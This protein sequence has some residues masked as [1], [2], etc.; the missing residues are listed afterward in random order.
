MS[1]APEI[2]ELR[3][4]QLKSDVSS[5][6]T[7]R[8]RTF[9]LFAFVMLLLEFLLN[10]IGV[11]DREWL[12]T[13]QLDSEA[14]VIARMIPASDGGF[15]AVGGFLRMIDGDFYGNIPNAFQKYLESVPGLPSARFT[16]YTGQVGLHG[17]IFAAADLAMRA[18]GLE[19]WQR[20]LLLRIA[21]A[22]ACAATLAYLVLKIRLEF[23]LMCA[24][25]GLVSLV[26]SPWL[27]SMAK[28]IYWVPFTWFL[29]MALAWRGYVTS[30]PPAGKQLRSIVLGIG[31]AVALKCLCGFEYVT[32]VGGA[33]ASV[34]AYGLIKSGASW[35]LLVTH[36]AVLVGAMSVG[37]MSALF[38]QISRL[39]MY[40]GSFSGA[41]IDFIQRLHVHTSIGERL[42]EHRSVG[43]EYLQALETSYL[44]TL[45]KYIYGSPIFGVSPHFWIN[46]LPL[47][48]LTIT[49]MTSVG[50]V[51]LFRFRGDKARQCEVLALL[52]L[53]VGAAVSSMSWFVFA[54]GHSDI[55][56]HINFVL[57]HVPYFFLAA[58]IC[59]RL[60]H[61]SRQ[62]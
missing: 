60:C 10:P 22:S 50:A 38:I 46:A 20:L 17:D 52:A 28:N 24:V 1:H 40:M 27:T 29:P 35:R 39:G 44:A 21:V 11:A 6:A 34:A 62:K 18:A 61:I 37:V 56:T 41:W 31:A 9:F 7:G 55:H 5:R 54:H 14:I 51:L 8:H 49:F 43:K 4:P 3:E 32:S 58:P 53:A 2:Q 19:G 33:A 26:F 59:I 57:W 15:F 25:A 30:S 48:T 42:Y 47:L 13:H 45:W 23:G 16:P 36:A 12:E